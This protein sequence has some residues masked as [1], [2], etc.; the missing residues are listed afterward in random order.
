VIKKEYELGIYILVETQ[1]GF[2]EL[3]PLYTSFEFPFAKRFEK[4]RKKKAP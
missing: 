3:T 4:F 2:A 1:D